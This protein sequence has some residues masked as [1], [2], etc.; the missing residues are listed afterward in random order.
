[1]PDNSLTSVFE[2]VPRGILLVEEYNAL[3]VAISSALRKFAPLHRVQVADSFVEAETAAAA[4][5]PELFVIDLDPPPSGEIEFFS[6][7][8]A[9]H[10]GARVLVIATG[11][12]R[13]LR[14]ERGTAGAIQFIEKPFDL[15]EFGAAVQALL[16]PW[17][18]LP[19]SG[20]R[21]T[22][23]D[24]H[25]I[26]IIQ[27]K[28]LADSTAVI[29][30]AAA[31]DRSGEI[32]FQ[33][34]QIAHAAAGLMTGLAALEEIVGWEGARLSETE[35]PIE[36]PRTIEAPW[37]MVLLQI[38]RKL[39]QKSPREAL[40]A[41]A[42]QEPAAANTG[43]KILVIDD[44]EMLLIFVAD[45]LATADQN[46]QIL[47]TPSGAEG[48]RL[49]TSER[50]DLVLLDYSLT[51]M[52][53]DK[54]CR[55][56]LENPATARIPVLMMSGHLGELARTAGTYENVVAALPKPFL[57]GALICA[58]EK[59]IAAGPLPHFAG[60]IPQPMAFPNPPV[61]APIAPAFPTAEGPALPLPNG[62]GGAGSPASPTPSAPL[63]SWTSEH[64]KSAGAEGAP[65]TPPIPAGA[66]G[67]RSA[68]IHRPTQLS[69]TLS[70]KL[71]AMEFTTFF[72]MAKGRLRPFDGI[73]AVKLGDR[74]DP[75]GAPLASG[76][77]L[78]VISLA[79][80]GTIDTM[81]L[82]PTHQPPQLPVPSRFFAV[83]G[84]DFQSANAHS[85]L[86]LT[87]SSEAVMPIHLTATFELLAI[88]MSAAFEVAAL[89]VKTRERTVL[90]CNDIES[91]GKPF[92]VLETQLAP[93]SELQSL[94]VR[95]VP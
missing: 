45:V 1:V 82:V 4:M 57:S 49:A 92:E 70:F 2:S 62:D 25:I 84:S 58:V 67:A 17:A 76:F 41:A 23:R 15:A 16:G 34:G 72:D 65:P 48:L 53:G 86:L 38:V 37:Q 10:P 42:L 51:D 93:S 88:E 85:P 54:V 5:R 78:D 63:V 9:H 3:R 30:I 64:A 44:T 29:R 74:E 81:R 19:V 59:T 79:G 24:L 27:L 40:G 75:K 28:C 61:S 21:G 43:K 94:L 31:G 33:K 6:K 14:A 68:A 11:T 32:H 73:A 89:L 60:P 13:E 95:P 55:A 26:D 39:K 69:V 35:V 52:T 77:R 90:L 20:L 12:S 71:V 22:L 66:H 91:P 83:G 56:L 7:L 80:N 36:S 46:F 8:K 47:T 87:A 18:I 50:P